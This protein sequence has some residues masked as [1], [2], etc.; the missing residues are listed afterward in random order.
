M[1][2]LETGSGLYAVAATSELEAAQLY[3][4]SQRLISSVHEDRITTG[5]LGLFPNPATESVTLLAEPGEELRQVRLFDLAGRVVGEHRTRSEKIT[6]MVADLL[7]G[8]YVAVVEYAS[9]ARRAASL[10]V[11]R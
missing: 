7:P 9:G 2:I 5:T 8:R 11:I 3:R 1:D 6:L 4:L 10:V